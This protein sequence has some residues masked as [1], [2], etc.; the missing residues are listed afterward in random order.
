M[1]DLTSDKF[2][3][4]LSMIH[5][6]VTGCAV[7]V[8]SE[9]FQTPMVFIKE[10][11]TGGFLST[12]DV[13]YPA[14]PFYLAL[15]PETLKQMLLPIMHW[16]HNDTTNK[17]TI[18]W[19]PHDLGMFP[20][21]NAD[22]ANQEEMPVEESGNMLLMLASL[23]QRQNGDIVW[24]TPFRKVVDQWASFLK[25]NLPDPEDQL[26]T[27]DFLG[28]SPHNLNLAT[29]GIVGMGAYSVLL[30][31]WGDY[32]LADEWDQLA[33]KYAQEWKVMGLDPDTSMLPHYKQRYDQNSTWSTKY[34]LI[35]QYVLGTDTF[36][37]DVR[38]TENAFYQSQARKYGIPL[39]NRNSEQ[40]VDWLSW[41]G[42]LA[43]DNK[44]QQTVITDFIYNLA[45]TS[46]AREPL[47]DL[48]NVDNM[49]LH[50]G[51]IARFVL[52]GLYA[53]PILNAQARNINQPGLANLDHVFPSSQNWKLA[54]E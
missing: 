23:A 36:P 43:F 42:A 37:D 6:Q 45:H 47:T 53:I 16:S 22:A 46:S 38:I 31:Y 48:Y 12:V 11:S 3:T 39:D 33:K 18:D 10:M 8:W 34:N 15:A 30:R 35:W 32:K 1:S 50:G 2:A 17:V 26:C 25:D 54:S 7:T 51:F 14:S 41:M 13:I 44:E 29:K 24:L 9:Q 52:G 49:D 19:A 5:R 28:S 21:A 40:K 27:D 4:V 20:I